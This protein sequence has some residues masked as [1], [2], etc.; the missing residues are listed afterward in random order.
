MRW[1]PEDAAC[2]ACGFDWT[3]EYEQAVA[4]VAK[5]PQRLSDALA[6]VAFPTRRSGARWSASMYVW[7]LVDVM[8]IGTERLLTLDRDPQRGIPC[9]DEN[10]LATVRKYDR[11]SPAVGL[12]V[13]ELETG[14]WLGVAAT[15]PTEAVV[16]HATFGEL[17]ALELA[18]RLAHEVHHHTM[19][20]AGSR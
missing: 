8:R 4:V 19:D 3:I 14:V 6:L 9:W 13:F 15:V 11:L 20:V 10:E 17:G 1:V 2:A 16:E 5:G 7:H 12:A 18:R